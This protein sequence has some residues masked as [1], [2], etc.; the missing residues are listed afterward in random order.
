MTISPFWK[1]VV[2]ALGAL[3]IAIKAALVGDETIS[4]QEWVE[5]VDRHRH[6]DRGLCGS[7]PPCRTE[8]QVSASMDGNMVVLILSSIVGTLA[9]AS[10][11]AAIWYGRRH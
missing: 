4:T 3:A 2:A 6:H 10:V 11:I 8:P 5:I 1:T 7:E 9:L